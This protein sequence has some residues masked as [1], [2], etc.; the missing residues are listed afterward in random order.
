MH[1]RFLRT[2]TVTAVALLLVIPRAPAAD[3]AAPSTDADALVAAARAALA[4]GDTARALG[5]ASKAVEA[6]PDRPQGYAMRAAVYDARREFAKA[7]ADYTRVLAIAPDS[8]SAVH[9]RGEAHFR[10][11]RFRESLADFDRE[12][13]LDPSRA[14][15]HWQRGI[16]LYYAGEYARGAEQF[17][18]HRTVNPDDVENAAWHYLCVA[19]R[20]GAEAARRALMPVDGDPRVPMPQIHAM[21]A[22]RASPDEVLAAARAGSPPP[23]EQKRRLMYAHLYLG[24]YLETSGDADRAREH[25]R[26]AAGPYAMENDYMSDVARVH[27]ATLGQRPPR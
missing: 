16:T 5:F 3:P 19:R 1:A 13:E 15:H 4:T 22:G 26:L 14:P 6:A 20:S 25:V 23:A 7:V 21:F 11:G 27:A 2:T 18:L 17:E 24:L 12:I 10:L 8:A 9:R